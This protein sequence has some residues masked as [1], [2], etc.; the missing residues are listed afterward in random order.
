MKEKSNGQVWIDAILGVGLLCILGAG[1]VCGV[2][3]LVEGVFWLF[4]QLI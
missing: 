3:L 2:R 1:A 4:T